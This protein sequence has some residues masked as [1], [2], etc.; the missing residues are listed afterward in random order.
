MY[1]IISGNSKP[2]DEPCA[3]KALHHFHRIPK[4]G[5]NLVPEH[6]ETRSLYNPEKPGIEQVSSDLKNR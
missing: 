4:K 5:F 2:S 6:V 1:Y 3:L